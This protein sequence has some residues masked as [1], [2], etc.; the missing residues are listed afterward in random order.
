MLESIKT[1]VSPQ[2][3]EKPLSARAPKVEVSELRHHKQESCEKQNNRLSAAL[4]RIN[5][6]LSTS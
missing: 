6:I 1:I 3:D 5:S 2:N 4:S